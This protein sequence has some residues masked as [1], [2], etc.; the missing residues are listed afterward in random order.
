MNIQYT[1]QFWEK[2]IIGLI[3]AYLNIDV[4]LLYYTFYADSEFIIPHQFGSQCLRIWQFGPVFFQID[5]KEH[6]IQ[7]GD[8]WSCLF[9]SYLA[10][11]FTF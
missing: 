2:N 7:L 8:V 5:P 9:P 4:V 3:I 10:I 1:E 6:F 11:I